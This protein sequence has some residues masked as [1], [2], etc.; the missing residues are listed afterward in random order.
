M[1]KLE[2]KS[3]V[4][5]FLFDS[6]FWVLRHLL[7]WAIIYLDEIFNILGIVDYGPVDIYFFV[8]LILD[9]FLVYFNIYFLIPKYLKKSKIFYYSVLTFFQIIIVLFFNLSFFETFIDPI[10]P[11]EASDV[12]YISAYIE[13]GITQL[14]ILFPAVAITL[15]KTNWSNA[16]RLNELN[17]LRY[18]SELDY[19]KKQV[20]P[21]FLFNTLNAIYVQAKQKLDTVPEAIMSLSNLMRYQTYDGMQSTVALSKE[22]E[23]IKN[24]LAMEKMRREDLD[25]KIEMT[26]DLKNK[27]I[28]PLLLLP[29]IE[30]ACK[31]SL[32]IKSKE[33]S[34]V[35]LRLY[36]NEVETIIEIKNSMGDVEKKED[37]K[38][39]GLGQSN[40][41][42][43]LNL[44]YP[45][46][47]EFIVN[48]T[49]KIYSLTLKLKSQSNNF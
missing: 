19:L 32:Q 33:Q 24:Y 31:Y 20:N 26:N 11:E 35:H 15:F 46:E 28:Q 36:K 23:F 6:K 40:V 30:N 37:D 44:L 12:D 9:F 5:S 27:N 7:F 8:S 10:S 42:K 47:H 3:I 25:V 34:F 14:G 43:R 1:N 4:K 49:E 17:K 18:E 45:N 13:M 22:I 39:S 21:H 38:Y 41:K 16:S 2:N 48:S 29:L